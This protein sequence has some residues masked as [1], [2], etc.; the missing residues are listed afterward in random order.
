MTGFPIPTIHQA[1]SAVMGDVRSVGKNDRNQTQG[2][3]F[4][5]IDAVVNAVGPAL[6]AHGVVV[7]PDVRDLRFE[8]VEVGQKRTAMG[9]VLVTVGYRF[10]GPAGDHIDTCTVGEAMD[11]GDKAVSKAMSVAFRTCLLQALALPTTDIDPDAETYERAPTVPE[12]TKPVERI[13]GNPGPDEWTVDPLA[14]AKRDVW[15]VAHDDLGMDKD[16]LAAHYADRQGG[17]LAEA[18]VEELTAYLH[19]LR[20]EA[21]AAKEVPA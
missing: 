7:V 18:S 3:S 9:H 1:L 20:D 4:R 11:A 16:G 6:R 12:L 15:A 17:V 8:T 21:R 19:L 14:A 10:Y 2:F 5:G 13:K